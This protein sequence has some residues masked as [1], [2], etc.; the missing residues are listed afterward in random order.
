MNKLKNIGFNLNLDKLD[1]NDST[2][3]LNVMEKILGKDRK[4]AI[5][6]YYKSLYQQPSSTSTSNSKFIKLPHIDVN[7][8]VNPSNT[9][10]SGPQYD[11]HHILT[12]ETIQETNINTNVTRNKSVVLDPSLIVVAAPE[13]E[14]FRVGYAAFRNKLSEF[15]ISPYLNEL[16][17]DNIMQLFLFS[18]QHNININ[19]SKFNGKKEF[20]L[21]LPQY[22]KMTYF[23]D[24]LHFTPI[25]QN[26]TYSPCN[27]QKH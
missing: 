10:I 20:E 2:Q 23:D 3:L 13:P 19:M 24:I 27:L 16:G 9:S 21:N 12:S 1:T 5:E 7:V 4:N 8:N 26:D 17:D 6:E 11:D 14:I 15:E 25:E 18:T 22:E